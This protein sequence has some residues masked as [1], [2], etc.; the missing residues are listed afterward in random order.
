M[1]QTLLILMAVALVG[2][3]KKINEDQLTAQIEED[4]KR[5]AVA[6]EMEAAEKEKADAV[7]RQQEK[8]FLEKNSFTEKEVNVWTDVRLAN[9]NVVLVDDMNFSTVARKYEITEDEAYEIYQKVKGEW[10]DYKTN[11]SFYEKLAKVEKGDPDALY[12]LGLSYGFGFTPEGRNEEEALKCFKKAS[13]LGHPDAQMQIASL[14]FY[15]YTAGITAVEVKIDKVLGYAWQ[16]LAIKNGAGK[17][18]IDGSEYAMKPEMTPDQITK[19]EALVKEM[20][21]KN[22]KLLK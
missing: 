14:Y 21:K 19:A 12:S 16:E 17:T 7:S 3:G 2:C 8:D 15:G 6:Q 4:K 1:K 13:E 20:I 5:M 9:K 11:L 18:A 10:F 22:P